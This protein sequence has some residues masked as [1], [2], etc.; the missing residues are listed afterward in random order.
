MTAG[1]FPVKRATT[2]AITIIKSQMIFNINKVLRR[3]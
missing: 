2:T 3:G 1:I